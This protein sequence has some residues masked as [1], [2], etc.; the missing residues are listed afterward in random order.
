MTYLSKRLLSI[1]WG[2]SSSASAPAIRLFI[3][4]FLIATILLVNGCGKSHPNPSTLNPQ[5]STPSSLSPSFRLHW[6]GKK[7]LAAE[8]N[9]TNFVSI[10]NMPESQRL[11]SQ[12]LDKLSTAPWRLLTTATP[13]SNAPTALLRSLLDDLVQE[14][15]YIEIVAGTNQPAESVLAI[16]LPPDRA[17]VWQTNLPIILKSIFGEASET[18]APAADYQLST[19]DHHLTLTFTNGWTILSSATLSHPSHQT[20]PL[21]DQQSAAS[22]AASI[23]QRLN[24]SG[25]PCGQSA[26]SDW[27]H[28]NVDFRWLK[29]ALAWRSIAVGTLPQCEFSILGDAGNVRTLAQFTFPSGAP[30]KLEPWNV[31]TNLVHDPLTAFT[32]FR[33][34]K[35]PL[36]F[37]RLFGLD[38]LSTSNSSLFSWAVAGYPLQTYLAYPDR[39]AADTVHSL[40][41]KLAGLMASD[42]MVGFPGKISR[43]TNETM[44][45]MDGLPFLSPR[46]GA[47]KVGQQDF[48]FGGLIPIM[49]TNRS[50]PVELIAQLAA[51]SDLIYYDWEVTGPRIE[52]WIY[53]SQ[54]MRLTFSR[55]QL[56]VGSAGLSWLQAVMHRAGNS[57]T[58]V[59]LASPDRLMLTRTSTFGFTGVEL[60]FLAD[61]LESPDFPVGLNTFRSPPMR[62]LMPPSVKPK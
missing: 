53:I 18:K 15:T 57:T 52:A 34:V 41:N 8:P 30:F 47:V 28:G 38:V 62:G 1:R 14:E 35:S 55:A 37:L 12:T 13:L 42:S 40:S 21:T 19:K 22:L 11:E 49:S 24:A 31:P 3:H 60:H 48:V 10:W 20:P 46:M 51:G 26:K 44:L 36:N 61:W 54:T 25:S 16:K 58:A 27:L 2:L 17:A 4:G 5:G 9:A 33:G 56:P 59:K 32:A 23:R 6:L 43:K 7:R 29:Y 39:N 45:V 50:M